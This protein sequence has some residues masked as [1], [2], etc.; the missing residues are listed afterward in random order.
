MSHYGFGS[1]GRFLKYTILPFQIS[2]CT[3]IFFNDSVVEVSPVT[4][5]SMQPTLSPNFTK[6]GSRDYVI[7]KKYKPTRD[8]NRGDI[9][10]FHS[11]QDPERL[12]VKRVVALGGDTVLLDP[13]RRPEEVANGRLN[14]YCK[15]WDVMFATGRGRKEI[16][17]GHIW[18]EG[19][20]WRSTHDSNAY[21]PISK[22]LIQGKAV[23]IF[24]PLGQFGSRPWEDFASRTKVIPGAGEESVRS[25]TERWWKPH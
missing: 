9:V 19:D 4:G 24:V 1:I 10:L 16:P 12:S 17:E 18:V 3:V 8:L 13:R 2:A 15:N 22:S 7:Y 23:G 25:D 20:N 11:L 21:G 14:P 6:D 5:P